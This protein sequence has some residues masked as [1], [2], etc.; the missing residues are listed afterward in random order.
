[1]TLLL[2]TKN[3]DNRRVLDGVFWQLR[4]EAPLAD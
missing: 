1:M 4:T 2:L 3:A